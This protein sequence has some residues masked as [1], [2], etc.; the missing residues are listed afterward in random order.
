MPDYGP[1]YGTQ[2]NM[3]PNYIRQQIQQTYGASHGGQRLDQSGEDYWVN[4]AT[5]P[6]IY[7]D[8]K[9]RVGWNPYWASRLS[10]G[11]DSADPN[12]AGN[13]GVI[14]NPQAFGLNFGSQNP[15]Y[16]PSGMMQAQPINPGAQPY[17]PHASAQQQNSGGIFSK[18]PVNTN[19]TLLG[20]QFAVGPSI[21]GQQD[22][23]VTP[24]NQVNSKPSWK[25]GSSVAGALGAPSFYKKQMTPTNPKPL[26]NN[27]MG[28][29][30]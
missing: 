15:G 21:G 28:V 19:G 11:S 24:Q 13:E 12:L 27:N 20:T 5:T 17:N 9:T 30:A 26:P 10:T 14:S 7:S 4:K 3:D 2:A 8:G 18:M 25:V 23:N 29:S 6:D 22:N 1:S 16:G